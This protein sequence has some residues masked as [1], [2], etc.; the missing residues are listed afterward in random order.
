V[1]KDFHVAIDGYLRSTRRIVDSTDLEGLIHWITPDIIENLS[2]SMKDRFRKHLLM[3]LRRRLGIPL[4]QSNYEIL[5][6]FPVFKNI[7]A[8]NLDPAAFIR[9]GV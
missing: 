3:A 9:H 8:C 6:K 5:S 4:A 2:D 7:V 1:E